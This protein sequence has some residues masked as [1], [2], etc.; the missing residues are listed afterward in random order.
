[1]KSIIFWDVTPCSLLSCNRRFGGTYRLHLQGRRIS[2]ACHLLSRLVL[3][4]FILRT[5]RWRRYVPPN[6]RLQLNRLHGVTSQKM[7]LFCHSTL[8]MALT[9]TI[10]VH[11][12]TSTEYN[13][14]LSVLCR[15]QETDRK[16]TCLCVLDNSDEHRASWRSGNAVDS[17]SGSARFECRPT[18]RCLYWGLSWF[19]PIPPGKIVFR[20]DHDRLLQ[21]PSQFIIHLLSNHSTLYSIS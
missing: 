14:T 4:R 17:S 20:L 12:G 19:S 10:T 13:D 11:I 5:W 6:R 3:A 21:N 1:M 18:H 7:I 9:A 2:S 8:H 16:V 15:K